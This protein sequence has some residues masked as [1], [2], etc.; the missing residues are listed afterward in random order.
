MLGGDQYIID[1]KRVGTRYAKLVF[2]HSMVFMSHIVHSGVSGARNVNALFF[3]LGL[4]QCGFP[5]KCT[6]IRYAELV[7]LHLV[8]SV[9]HIVHSGAFGT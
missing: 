4:A 7:L 1:K 9:G 6:R 2:L 3:M 8:C 5:K